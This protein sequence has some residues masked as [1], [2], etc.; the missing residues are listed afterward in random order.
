MRSRRPPTL[1]D[2]YAL[3]AAVWDVTPAWMLWGRLRIRGVAL[4]GDLLGARVV[5]MD[6]I[7]QVSKD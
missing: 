5:G 4:G 3:G 2:E 6:A 7:S 1:G